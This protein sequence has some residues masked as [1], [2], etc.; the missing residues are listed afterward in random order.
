MQQK[1]ITRKP[2][3]RRVI[4]RQT[5]VRLRREDAKRVESIIA[6]GWATTTNGAIRYALAVASKAERAA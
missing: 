3:R 2:I 1:A 4:T 6:G 5:T